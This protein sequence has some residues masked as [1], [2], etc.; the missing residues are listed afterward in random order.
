MSSQTLVLSL[1]IPVFNEADSLPELHRRLHQVLH[2]QGEP[3]EII[4]VNDGSS[5]RSLEVMKELR[6]EDKAV[7]ILSL[8]RNMGH[9]AALTA[10]L[11]H[12]NG[13]AVIVMDADLQHPPELIP[14]L[15]EKW[16]EGFEI[17]YTIR[18]RTEGAGLFKDTT[19]SLYYRLLKS[20]SQVD[21]Q[22]GAADF[23]LMGR[24]SLTSFISMRER[25]RFLRGLVGWLGFRSTSVPYVAEKRFA[26]SPKYSLRSMTRFALTGILSFST[27]PLRAAIYAGLGIALCSG[28]YALFAILTQL[29]TDRVTAGWASLIVVT[30]FLGSVQLIFLGILGEYIGTIMEE[31]KRRPLYVIEDRIGFEEPL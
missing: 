18:E 12:A 23:R 28:L 30:L 24:K 15:V 19:A 25:R 5:D 4:L 14:R 13:Q 21:I 3:H 1:V 2:A 29:F 8:S 7:K 10:G 17:V 22:P 6:A 26:G 9:Q 16:R 11:D 27:V 31:V 20:I